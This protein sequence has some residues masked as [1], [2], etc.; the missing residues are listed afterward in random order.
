MFLF[1]CFF[2]RSLHSLTTA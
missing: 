1:F 2:I